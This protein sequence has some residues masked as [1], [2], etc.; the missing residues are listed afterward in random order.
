MGTLKNLGKAML[1]RL[2]ITKKKK[3]ANDK[4]KFPNLGMAID[5]KKKRK[6]ALEAANKP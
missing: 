4:K 1:K 3:K 5:A 6:K 2:G